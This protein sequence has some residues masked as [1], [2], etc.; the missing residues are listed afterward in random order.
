MDSTQGTRLE[1]HD[2]G[3][4]DRLNQ[5]EIRR[6]QVHTEH[7]N[8]WRDLTRVDPNATQE[9]REA[10]ARYCDVVLELERVLKEFETLRSGA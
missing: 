2:P 5:L 3:F 4:R 7:D 1:L 6:R 9:Q 8:A 10:W